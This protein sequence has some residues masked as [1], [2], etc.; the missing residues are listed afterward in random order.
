MGNFAACIMV[1]TLESYIPTYFKQALHL[2][3]KS[4]G[5][6]SALPYLAQW[7]SKILFAVIADALKTKTSLDHTWICRLSNCL[8]TF[9]AGALLI[10]CGYMDCGQIPLAVFFLTAANFVSSGQVTGYFTSLVCIAP[11]YTGLVNAFARLS[12][13]VASVIA[14]HIVGALT[15]K[16][17]AGEWMIVYYITSAALIVTGVHFMVFGS[18]KVQSWAIVQDEPL[19]TVTVGDENKN[20]KVVSI[21]ASKLAGQHAKVWPIST[22]TRKISSG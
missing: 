9:V 19:A 4:N 20:G 17:T 14:P 1:A 10:A 5:M 16:G 3:L 8:N 6:L 12:G 21:E 18:A 13:Q 15:V 22:P 2:D 7:V 11:A